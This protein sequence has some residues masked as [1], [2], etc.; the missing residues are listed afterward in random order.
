MISL[1]RSVLV[2]DIDSCLRC[3]A[4]EIACRTEHELSF[5]TKASWCRVVTVGPRR[6]NG[7]LYMDFVPVMC[8][9]CDDPL[10]LAVCPSGAIS[11]NSDGLVVVDE[12]ACTGCQTCVTGCLYGCMDYNRVKGTAGHCDLCRGRGEAGLEPACVQHCI[13]GALQFVGPDDLDKTTSGRHT[14]HSGRICYV[15]SRWKLGDDH[16]RQTAIDHKVSST[17]QKEKNGKGG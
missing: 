11:K 14:L 7:R 15:S 4:C 3:H 16:T 2:I 10:C 6:L 8:R 9:H 5:E 12:E 1:S 13:G 17:S